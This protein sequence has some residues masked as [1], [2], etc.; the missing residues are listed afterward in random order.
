VYITKVIAH[1]LGV[2]DMLQ[3][4]LHAACYVVPSALSRNYL[5]WVIAGPAARGLVA[6]TR[7]QQ[8]AMGGGYC[9]HL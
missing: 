1:R 8:S 4:V 5:L 6:L 2:L 3:Y 7:L 9:P